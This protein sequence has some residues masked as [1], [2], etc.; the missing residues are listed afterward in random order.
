VMLATV[1]VLFSGD[2]SDMFGV[3]KSIAKLIVSTYKVIIHVGFQM[4]S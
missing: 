4:D 3:V 2:R 1:Y